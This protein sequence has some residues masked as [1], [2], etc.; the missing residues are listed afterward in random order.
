[1]LQ[2]RE[3][4]PVGGTEALKVDTRVLAATNRD[5]EAEIK[6]GAFRSDL[7]YRLNVIA[8]HL[9]PLR[10]RRED[11]P[12]L[13]AAFLARQADVQRRGA[14][15]CRAGRRRACS[16]YAWPGN[17]REL[18]NALERAVI[19]SPARRSPSARCRARRRAPRRAAR[20]RA[21]A[22]TPTLGLD[23]ARLHLW[24]LQNEGGQQ[25]ARG[26]GAR[27]RS[28]DA[29]PQAVAFGVEA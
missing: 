23:R 7:F 6:R 26:R 22:A 1:V 24:V 13:A 10:E 11:I 5:L 20:E 21:R 9:P 25:D 28:V 27:H 29:V 15:A 8:I 18:E 12:L 2:E 19:L 4:I 14:Q 16:R 17:V 3:V